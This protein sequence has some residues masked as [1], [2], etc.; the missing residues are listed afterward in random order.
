MGEFVEEGAV[1]R[2]GGLVTVGACVG[3][4]VGSA[5]T[6]GTDLIDQIVGVVSTR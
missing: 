1:D 2:V 5:D 4:P 6:D 3:P